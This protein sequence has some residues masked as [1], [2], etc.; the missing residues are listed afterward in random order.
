MI[1]LGYWVTSAIRNSCWIETRDS[2]WNVSLSLVEHPTTKASWVSD[3]H[4]LDF[5]ILNTR[6]HHL[7]IQIN[8]HWVFPKNRHSIT[9]TLTPETSK[10]G[11]LEVDKTDS[12]LIKSPVEQKKKLAISFIKIFIGD[13]VYAYQCWRSRK[14]ITI[15]QYQDCQKTLNAPTPSSL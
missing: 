1:Y 4:P 5:L 8:Q 3:V 9:I 13:D 10:S 2:S 11:K 7:S 14:S 15:Y 6:N 12:A